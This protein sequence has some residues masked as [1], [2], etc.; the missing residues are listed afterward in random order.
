VSLEVAQAPWAPTHRL[1]RIGLKAREVTTA[2]RPAANLVFLLD[3]SGSMNQPNKLPLVKQAM[4]LLVGKLRKDD[5]VAIVTYAGDSGLALP[6]TPVAQSREILN[7][8]DALTP[9]GAT[10][11]AMGIQLAYEIARANFVRNG[12]NR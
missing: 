10:N 6:S 3:V 9:G 7:A 8:L 2:Q 4:R 1:V 12:I 5:R 11:G